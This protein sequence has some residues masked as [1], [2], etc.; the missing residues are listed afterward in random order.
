VT[1]HDIDSECGT[2]HYIDSE[3]VALHDIDS[4]CV[5]LHDIDSECA[6]LHDD[7]TVAPRCAEMSLSAQISSLAARSRLGGPPRKTP[8]HEEERHCVVRCLAR[9]LG[10]AVQVVGRGRAC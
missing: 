1:L 3:C 7:E 8:G 5:T 9:A 2:L 6:T 4:E 10:T